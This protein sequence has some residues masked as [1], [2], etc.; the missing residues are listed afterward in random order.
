MIVG[1]RAAD[2]NVLRVALY[3]Q[4]LKSSHD[5]L[6]TVVEG[7]TCEYRNPVTCL[8]RLIKCRDHTAAIFVYTR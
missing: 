6:R 3:T 7:G 8:K 5:P 4:S 2:N 1:K